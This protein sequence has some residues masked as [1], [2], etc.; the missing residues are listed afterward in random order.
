MLPLDAKPAYMINI[1]IEKELYEICKPVIKCINANN[2][3]CTYTY[4]DHQTIVAEGST[5]DNA[6]NSASQILLSKFFDNDST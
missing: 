5:S 2:F 1:M 6:K 4:S 3:E